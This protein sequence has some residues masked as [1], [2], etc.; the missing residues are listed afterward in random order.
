MNAD[1][2]QLKQNAPKQEQGIRPVIAALILLILLVSLALPIVL[3]TIEAY[4]H[5]RLRLGLDVYFISH[6]LMRVL[7]VLLGYVLI[8]RLIKRRPTLGVLVGWERFAVGLGLGL[9]CTLP[10]LVIGAM[11]GMKDDTEYRFLYRGTLVAALNEE[12]VF[13]AFGFGLLVQAARVGLWPA[14][15]ITG[16]LFGAVHLDFTP[17]EGQT[18]LGQVDLFLLLTTLGGVLYAWL[19]HRIGY[20]LWFVIALHLF[21]NLWWGIFDVGGSPLGGFGATLSRVL[22]V[23]A[24]IVLVI[25]LNR[26]AAT[27]GHDPTTRHA[28]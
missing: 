27:I 28:G 5:A 12:F 11:G 25:V 20:N 22:C 17:D 1:A 2:K 16:V 21:M 10:M 4:N 8:A 18:I 3:A 19:Y 9:L 24:A 6:P 14:A 23:T 15:I 13:R 7:I 26:R